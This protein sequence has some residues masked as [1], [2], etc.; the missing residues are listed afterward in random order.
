VLE[1][2]AEL[3]CRSKRIR[4]RDRHRPARAPDARIPRDIYRLARSGR[5]SRRRTRA[6]LHVADDRAEAIALL[7]KRIASLTQPERSDWRNAILRIMRC[8]RTPEASTRSTTMLAVSGLRTLQRRGQRDA[9][10]WTRIAQLVADTCRRLASFIPGQTRAS[11][12]RTQGGSRVPKSA[13]SDLCGGRA[14]MRVPT[15]IQTVV[16]SAAPRSQII[17]Q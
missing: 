9:S 15:A 17:A 5:R 12:S 2:A 7:E 13:R 4:T 16:L 1:S 6:H 14:A 11:P 10:T 3:A 8:Q